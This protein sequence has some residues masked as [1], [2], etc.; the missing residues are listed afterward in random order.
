MIQISKRGVTSVKELEILALREDFANKK[1]VGLPNLIERPFAESLV[2]KLNEAEFYPNNHLG[3]DRQEFA[4]DLTIRDNNVVLH[5]IHFIL[6]NPNFF[7]TV[8]KITNCNS[9]GS[10]SGRIYRSL[11][12]KSHQLDW[13]DDTE[14]KE[15]LIGISINLSAEKYLDGCFQ[16]RERSTQK[17][18]HEVC[19]GNPGDAHIFQISNNL[20][21][22]VT[23]TKGDHPRTSAAGWFVSAPQISD[24][25]KI[26]Y[27]K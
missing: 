1:C 19:C 18:L 8:Q 27:R 11:P 7:Q 12:E 21:H 23:A 6:N 9:I 22:R 2:K 14:G 25:L 3:K 20:Q 4:T 17:V 13:H 16:I 24:V 15:R 26:L 10:F 5:Q